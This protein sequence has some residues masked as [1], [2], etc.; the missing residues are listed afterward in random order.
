MFDSLPTREEEQEEV[1]N[2][3]PKKL[4]ALSC[5]ECKSK[6]SKYKCPGCSF[7]SCSLP[8]VK[9]HKARTGCNGKR[10]ITH[11]VPLS[12]FDDNILLSDYNMLEEVKRVVES[13][14]RMRTQ[15]G[16]HKKFKLPHHLRSLQSAAWSRR[17]KLLFLPSGM[18]R[19]QNNQSQYDKRKKYIYWT[20]EWHFHSTN[21][22]L[23]DH[24]VNEN[25]SFC[26]ILEK[27]LKPGPWN[28]QL[29]QFCEQQLDSLKLFI[30]PKG[31]T[32]PLKE[33]DMKAPIGQQFADIIILEYPIV[34]VFSPYQVSNFEVNKNV[35]H[36]NE[37][38]QS[39]EDVPFREEVVEYQNNNTAYEKASN[40][41]SDK[42][43]LEEETL[44]KH[45][46]PENKE[47]KLSKDIAFDSDQDLMDF[48]DALMAQMNPDDLLGL[49]K[50]A[51]NTANYT[52][53]IGSCGLF[54]ELEEGELA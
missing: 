42:P 46:H 28:H 53:L 25:A 27:H 3:V 38:N 9:L 21:V 11:F 47:A 16:L 13:A 36:N 22:I 20:I 31:P 15:L 7:H 26:S 32:S 1:E 50:F 39:Q 54:P 4:S 29:R 5:E 17:T 14:H 6:P 10:N 23:H 45:S 19:R 30:R 52:D 37:S 51:K 49:D 33:L 18:S 2:D 40:E 41:S 34:Y 48:Y 35:N 24:E 43:I 12:H 8:C 44:T